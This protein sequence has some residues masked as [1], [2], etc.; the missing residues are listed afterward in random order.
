[1]SDSS[2][3]GGG[4]GGGSYGPPIVLYAASIHEAINSGDA[5]R[6]REV[7]QAAQQTI[8]QI[9]EIKAAHAKLRQHLGQS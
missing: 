8:D 7:E 2:G 9:D 1:M 5:A 3:Y 4:G 6:Q